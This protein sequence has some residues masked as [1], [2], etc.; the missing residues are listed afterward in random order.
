MKGRCIGVSLFYIKKLLKKK[1]KGIDSL[2]EGFHSIKIFLNAK[3]IETSQCICQKGVI[4]LEAAVILPFLAGFF[5]FLLFYFRIMQVQLSVQNALEETGRYLA[6]LSAEE[7]EEKDALENISY[8]MLAKTLVTAKLKEDSWIE[9]YVVGGVLG[10]SLLA[11]EWDGDYLLIRANYG[12][13]FPVNLFGSQ[14]FF[15]S[16]KTCFRKWIGWHSADIGNQNEMMIYITKSGSVYHK[17][18]S[19]PYLDLSVEK[20]ELSTVWQKRNKNGGK[21]RLCQYCEIKNTVTE[22]VYITNYG[23]C[24][25]YDINCSGLKRT[26]YQKRLSEVGEKRA[27]QKCW[28]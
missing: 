13:K 5:V 20:T 11:S 6:V 17:W 1:K 23:E 21:Y 10:I 18:I 12:M 24:Y 9:E 14:M 2:P 28:K 8:L 25:H 15:I 26:I 27:C 16:Q 4:T 19:C 7:L 22:D 3:K